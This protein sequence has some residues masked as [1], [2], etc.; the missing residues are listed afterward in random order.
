[1]NA[2]VTPFRTDPAPVQGAARPLQPCG[3]EAAYRRHIKAR[4]KP[5][6]PCTVAHRDAGRRWDKRRATRATGAPLGRPR[7]RRDAAMEEWEFFGGP[8]GLIDFH[9]FA[10]RI[11][12]TFAAWERHYQRAQRDGDPRATGRRYRQQPQ[13]VAS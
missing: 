2:T 4:E 3:S 9:R 11:G 8:E 7:T 1:M 6:Q 10:D 5:C 12:I 13:Q